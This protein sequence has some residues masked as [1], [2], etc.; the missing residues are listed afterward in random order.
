MMERK[1]VFDRAYDLVGSPALVYINF[2]NCDTEV[3]VC[4]GIAGT[5]AGDLGTQIDYP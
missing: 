1:R 3:N 5:R 2:Y 4:I